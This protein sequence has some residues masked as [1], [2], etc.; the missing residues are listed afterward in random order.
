MTYDEE[1]HEM[2]F[3]RVSCFKKETGYCRLMSLTLAADTGIV[4]LE[5]SADSTFK[6]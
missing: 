4:S 6:T 5:C 1:K 3:G 2:D